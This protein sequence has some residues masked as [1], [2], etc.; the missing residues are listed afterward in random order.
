MLD[1]DYIKPIP[2]TLVATIKREDKKR[3][4]APCGNT[5]FYSYLATWHKELVKITVAV[6]Y[7]KEK[8]YCKQVAV[9]GLRS[10]NALV[11]D[12]EYFTVA[13][14]VVGWYDIKACA[15]SKHWENGK[16]Y[17]CK[18]KY[19]DMYA[20]CVNLDYL[21]HFS[22]YRYSE[23]KNAYYTEILSYLRLYEEF[24]ETEYLIKSGLKYY[25]TSKTILRQIRKDKSF[26]KWLVAHRDKAME[27]GRYYCNSILQA[28]KNNLPIAK[29]DVLE[30]RKRHLIA[31]YHGKDIIKYAFIK[32]EKNG[33]ERYFTYKDKHDISDYL[34]LDYIRACHFLNLD[35]H[36]DNI[37]YPK[38]FH[39]W[40][41]I[42]I[43]E[44]R[45]VEEEQERLREEQAK[46]EKEK[47][48]NDFLISA[49]KYLPLA[50]FIKDKHYAIFIAKSPAE[51]IKEGIALSHC[52]GHNGYDK[53]MAKQE[54]LIFFV[55]KI[56]E[57]DKPFVTIEYSLKT[58]KVLQCYA[59][60]N[61]KPEE[62]VL[63]FVNKKW[64]P[65]ANKQLKKIAA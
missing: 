62:K 55:R 56:E 39:R 15:R 54:T 4:P 36:D 51:L 63:N 28:Y 49:E 44:K 52:V 17:S 24:P 48:L 6:K 11:K 22:E 7:Y 16:W 23:Y 60:K 58:K 21:E 42:R 25:A 34:Y 13:G 30:Y 46:K 14:Y 37:R 3:Y 32:G 59:Y 53:K 12:V 8:W 9:H 19:F 26:H 43:E 57:L 20:P 45:I 18:R 47:I 29:V 40:H 31:D 35:C 41:D 64:L 27:N 1:K 50:G 65:Y 2:K 38:D 33:Y 61:S 5:R 10:E